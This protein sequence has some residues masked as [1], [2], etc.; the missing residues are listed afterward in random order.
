[1]KYFLLLLAPMIFKNSKFS[2]GAHAVKDSIHAEI[3]TIILKTLFGLV[4]AAIVIFSVL[5]FGKALQIIFS[6]YENGL[7]FELATFGIAAIAGCVVLFALFSTT[8]KSASERVEITPSLDIQGLMA[9]FN[10]GFVKGFKTTP[11]SDSKNFGA[12]P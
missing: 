4:L 9:Q 3:S 6:Q 2:E 7:Y 11:T 12:E 5:Q 8:K 1:M 10:D